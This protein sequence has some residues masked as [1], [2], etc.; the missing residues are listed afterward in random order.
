MTQPP[1]AE[2]YAA[3]VNAHSGE[4]VHRSLSDVHQ[5][6][7][8]FTDSQ[9]VLYYWICKNDQIL[10]QWTRNRVLKILRSK[11]MIAD[12]GTRRCSSIDVV[13]QESV[14]IRGFEWMLGDE[15]DFPM[16]TSEEITLSN[17]DHRDVKTEVQ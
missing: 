3:L 16:M 2:L 15:A 4:V 5:Q 14:W 10:K 12:I 9:I 6:A 17:Q 7:I 13:N 1:R 8:K 11:D